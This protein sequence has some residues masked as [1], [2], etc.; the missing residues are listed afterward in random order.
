M[1]KIITLLALVRPEYIKVEKNEV[2]ADGECDNDIRRINN[3]IINLSI[4]TKKMSFRASFL[5]LKLA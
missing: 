4:K 5:F 3:G 2:S 1:L